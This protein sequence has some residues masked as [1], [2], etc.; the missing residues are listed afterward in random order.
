MLSLLYLCHFANP[1]SSWTNPVSSWRMWE[2]NSRGCMVCL[3]VIYRSLFQTPN[4]PN[5]T[6]KTAG[7]YGLLMC[8]ETGTRTAEPPAHIEKNTARITD[9]PDV[10]NHLNL[11]YVTKACGKPSWYPESLPCWYF[12]WKTLGAYYLPG[13]LPTVLLL[14]SYCSLK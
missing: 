8:W 12:S 9:C 5:L 13:T 6:S 2:E 14:W 1:I 10:G 11:K 3:T 4:T 7:G